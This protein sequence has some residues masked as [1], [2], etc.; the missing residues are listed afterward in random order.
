M[1]II[2]RI[3]L[4]FILILC[5]TIGLAPFTPEPHFWEKLKMLFS[6]QLSAT[7][8]MIDM[9]M[10]GAPW[11]LLVAKLSRTLSQKLR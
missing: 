7:V 3:P 1:R 9:V 11:M 10:H 8:D 5:V 4:V 6:G 2:D